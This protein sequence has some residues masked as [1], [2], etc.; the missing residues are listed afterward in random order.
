MHTRLIALIVL[1]ILPAPRLFAQ[2]SK[3]SP[4]APVSNTATADRTVQILWEADAPP[5]DIGGA[6]ERLLG[7]GVVEP[8]GRILNVKDPQHARRLVGRVGRLEIS[9]NTCKFSFH[10]TLDPGGGRER[11]AASE[12]ADALVGRLSTMLV[13]QRHE[14]TA[15]RENAARN[16]VQELDQQLDAMRRRVKEQAAGLHEL[17]GRA[18]LSPA[19][20]QSSLGKL[21]DERQRIEL[22]LAGMEARLEAV[23][24]Q[25][26]AAG[27]EAKKQAADDPVLGELEKAVAAREKLL[28]IARRQYEAGQAPATEAGKAEADLI[29]AR[30]QLLDRKHAASS[31][32]GESVALFTREMRN[33]G[34]DIRDRRARLVHVQHR[35]KPL[36]EVSQGFQELEWMGEEMTT[37]RKLL[38]DA[39]GRLREAR[40]RLDA[41]PVDRVIVTSDRDAAPRD[42]E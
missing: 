2:E 33:L 6:I 4:A 27:D 15:V 28:E 25:I 36:R 22:D 35:L 40:R 23:Q 38:E 31:R 20:V 11:L 7:D 41:V 12:M 30:I 19:T 24:E 39:Q 14:E 32:G 9:D 37:V 5:P 29:D 26:K 42:A 1:A 16:E 21:E 8:A 3:P 13:E 34:I 10:V 18:D 17:A